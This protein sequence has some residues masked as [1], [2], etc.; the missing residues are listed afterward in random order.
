[1]IKNIIYD[2]GGVIY[3][4]DYN[5]CFNAF[6]DIGIQDIEQAFN[7]ATQ[8]EFFHQLEMGCIDDDDFPGFLMQETDISA[9]EDEV[10][11]AWMRLLKGF[12]KV[13]TNLM[14]ESGKHYFTFI[15]SN[16]NN[17]HY[18]A[19]AQ[20]FFDI[21]QMYLEEAVHE[22]YWSFERYMRKPDAEFFEALIDEHDLIPEETLFIDDTLS[23]VEAAR[24]LGLKTLHL[25]DMEMLQD[26]FDNK[27]RLKEEMIERL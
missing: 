3:A 27:G 2:F 12:H 21:K 18:Q 22:A 23:N 15:L 17:I 11:F 14:I 8:S 5:D 7:K 19:F 16:T 4:I 24:K 13:N 26:Y 20:Q 9:T 6:R 25:T 10:I 1:M